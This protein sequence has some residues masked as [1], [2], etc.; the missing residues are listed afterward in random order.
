MKCIAYVSRTTANERGITLP[1]GLS[2]IVQ[3]S[4][5]RNPA[6]QITGILS[7]RQ[8]Q[9]VQVLEGP[10]LEVDNL[11]AKVTADPRHKD[12]WVFISERVIER[13]FDSWGVSIFDFIDQGPIFKTFIEHHQQTLNAFTNEQK[14]RLQAFIHLDNTNTV[15]AHH[16]DGKYLRLLAWPDL[17]RTS[18]PQLIMSLCVKLTKKPYA[19]D[20][21]VASEEFGTYQQVTDIIKDFESLGIL[22]VSEPALNAIPE[23]TKPQDIP[24]KKPSKFYGAIKRFLGMG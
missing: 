23:P 14:K 18:Q 20:S 3:M 22:T 6:A 2:N 11:M 7:Y 17:N 5:K 12:L 9:Y 24:T 19:F 21:L 10:A 16:Y 15:A 8:G 4:R 1:A 13:S